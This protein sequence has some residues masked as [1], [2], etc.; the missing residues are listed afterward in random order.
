MPRLCSS[1]SSGISATVGASIRPPTIRNSTV[2][3]KGIV[4]LV[5]PNAAQALISVVATTEASV[6]ITLLIRYWPTPRF[7]AST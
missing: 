3:E 1:G 2:R 4:S 6:T 5:R 7:Q